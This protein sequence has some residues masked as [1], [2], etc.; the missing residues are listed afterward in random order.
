M[1]NCLA[2][3]LIYLCENFQIKKKK[4]ENDSMVTTF[5]S[6]LSENLEK[7]DFILNLIFFLSFG[8]KLL[9]RDE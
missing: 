5:R 4:K 1:L 8:S 7:D 6:P 3:F 2:S 9:K